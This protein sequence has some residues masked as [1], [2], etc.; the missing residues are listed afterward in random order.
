M[1]EQLKPNDRLALVGFDSSVYNDLNLTDL[2][3][4]GKKNATASVNKLVPGSCTN[5]SGGLFE[6]LSV[7]KQRQG[8]KNDVCSVLL[9]TDGLANEG[10]TDSNAIATGVEKAIQ[11]MGIACTVFTF[12]FGA[13]HNENML[14][15]I[16]Q[17]G[18]G[19]YFFIQKIDEIPECF[20]SCLGGLMSV[21][22]QNSTFFWNGVT[23][24]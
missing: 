18:G 22:A 15:Q 17:V 6:G 21:V 11:E 3:E 23:F 19:M 13:D 2:D 5:L 16:S 7:L 12:G 4:Q 8:K 9:F 24:C 10:L 14:K 20:A 1:I